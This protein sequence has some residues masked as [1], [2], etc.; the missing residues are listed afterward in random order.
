MN[1]SRVIT[2]TADISASIAKIYMNIAQDEHYLRD[3]VILVSP[4][5]VIF[6]KQGKKTR[7]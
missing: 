4:E 2:K 7:S 1:D 6:Q 5:S 3:S